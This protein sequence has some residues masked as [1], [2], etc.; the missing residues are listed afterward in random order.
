MDQNETNSSGSTRAILIGGFA[1]VAV[2]ILIG[3]FLPPIS[4][5]AR[6]GL[7]ADA[8]AES[9]SEVLSGAEVGEFVTSEPA[10][11][12]EQVAVALS[13]GSADIMTISQEAFLAENQAA[14]AAEQGEITGD[15]YTVSPSDEEAQGQV[16]LPIP[17]EA[18]DLKT[19]DLFGWNGSEWEFI[20]SQKDAASGQIVSADQKL[21]QAFALMQ[22]RAPEAMGIAS[23]VRSEGKI[24]TALLPAIT[25]VTI[26]GLKLNS[27]GSLS[28]EV[29][30]QPDGAYNQW[31]RVSNVGPVIDQAALSNLLGSTALQQAQIEDLVA[32]ANDGGY[33][34]I[35][36][37]YQQVPENQGEAFSLFAANLAAALQEQELALAL[38]LGV[39][40]FSG[41]GWN[42]GGQ[43]WAALGKIADKI[44]VELPLDPTQYDLGDE[45]DQLLSFATGEIDRSKLNAVYS[46]AAVDRFG[47]T[48]S[49]MT[50]S[51]ALSNFGKLQFVQ[52]SEEVGPNE[53]V[54]V[55]LSGTANPLEWDG[56]SL[57]YKYSYEKDG[58]V[59]DVWLG[60]EAALNH[61][62]QQSAAYNLA[63][64]SIDGLEN[65]EDGAGY[66]AAI[67][68]LLGNGEAP[69][70]T[71]AA[72][73]WTVR[74][75]NDSVLASESG[76][77]LAFSWDVGEAV[78]EYTVK[79]DFA[80][81]ENIANLDTLAVAVKEVEVVEAEEPAAEG[82]D[83]AA[84]G[85]TAETESAEAPADEAAPTAAFSGEGD[86]VV[87]VGANVRTGPGLTYGTLTDGADPG[88]AVDLIGRNADSS[89]LN[90]VLPDGRE[91]WMFSSLLTLNP[92]TDV[93][94]LK[95]VE[96][97]AAVAAAPSSSADAGSAA[98]ADSGEA[99]ASAAAPPPPVAAAPVSNPGFELGGQSHTFANPQ[100]MASAG[101]NWVKFQHKWGPGDDRR[102]SCR[103]HSTGTCQVVLK[104]C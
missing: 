48:F 46:T 75:A 11:L 93:N 87:S 104:C 6:L 26:G 41:S 1:I 3:L 59:H 16:A 36:L 52:G 69:Q 72:I 100:L 56:D 19:L 64:I 91:G 50:N 32:R 15:V 76:S 71:G 73:V 38:R 58:Q 14:A 49:A 9:R 83:G 12:P 68:S 20:P 34:G 82:A 13:K 35:E 28:G 7:G 62:I 81:G 80:L 89:W 43:D 96:V 22:A 55:A 74:N 42:S 10:D 98:D 51:D 25:D 97:A 37:D 102:R 99:A 77:E 103:T 84:E 67:G 88:T 92:G 60:S 44:N 17:A 85:T 78:G 57:T 5:G 95:V 65:I 90:I 40:A 70:P 31:L 18:G 47:D 4:L 27:D 53:T 66:A 86:A 94:A 101:M 2:L 30:R 63:G 45:A 61:R 24:P 21:P 39:P 8:P 23:F 33:R 54:E 29:E 79:A